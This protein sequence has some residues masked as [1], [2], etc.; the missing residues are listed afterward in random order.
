MTFQRGKLRRE[1]GRGEKNKTKQRSFRVIF[2]PEEVSNMFW[3]VKPMKGIQ[4]Q[5]KTINMILNFYKQELTVKRVIFTLQKGCE[6]KLSK[7][8]DAKIAGRVLL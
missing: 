8:N 1:R 2:Y 3:D 6:N 7:L 4:L 5:G